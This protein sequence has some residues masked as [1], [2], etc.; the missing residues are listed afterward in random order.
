M[1]KPGVEPSAPVRVGIAGAVVQ[2]GVARA[3]GSE[4]PPSGSR[5]AERSLETQSS[6]PNA[7][8]VPYTPRAR[9]EVYVEAKDLPAST[10]FKTLEVETV[11]LAESIDP[12]KA[13]TQL[14]LGRVRKSEP[15]PVTPEGDVVELP[16]GLRAR[17]PGRSVHALVLVAC[18]AL[19][20]AGGRLS[21]PQA[22]ESPARG[23]A[24]PTAPA[25]A[26]GPRHF[27]APPAHGVDPAT[28]APERPALTTALSPSLPSPS[29]VRS[30]SDA[31][32][33]SSSAAERA[34]PAARTKS[35]SRS[36]MK[37]APL[38]VVSAEAPAKRAIY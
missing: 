5:P 25:L 31:A 28:P 18:A 10:S 23:A 9:H 29:S 22:P 2:A 30:V 1:P 7:E 27:G 34:L 33:P 35:S 20:F 26:L 36:K 38:P 6:A 17:W 3:S 16:P 8:E 11:K 19:G 24:A 14:K 15:P 37:K 12:R 4:P 32:L 13:E 21:A